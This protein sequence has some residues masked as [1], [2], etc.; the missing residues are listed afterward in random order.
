MARAHQS[1]GADGD[2]G[3][4]SGAD[5][6]DRWRDSDDL[7]GSRDPSPPRW[8]SEARLLLNKALGKGATHT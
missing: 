4:A 1:T 3:G 6:Q 8:Q 5:H 7:F 2:S